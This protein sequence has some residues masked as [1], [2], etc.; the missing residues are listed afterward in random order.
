[1]TQ[2]VQ[3]I[4]TN[5]QY[6]TITYPALQGLFVTLYNTLEKH[7][8]AYHGTQTTAPPALL[9]HVIAQLYRSVAI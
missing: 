1:M 3:N 6:N 9:Q 4:F 7:G 8:Q 2:Y 5:N